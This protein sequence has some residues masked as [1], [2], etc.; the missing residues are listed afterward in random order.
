MSRSI[1]LKLAALTVAA[2]ACAASMALADNQEDHH[3]D[4]ARSRH[5][6][7]ISIDGMH[8]LD[9]QN[10]SKTGDCPNLAAVA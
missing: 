1:Y 4:H 8:A 10:C 2:S 5:V 9:F 6:L 3:G 7:L